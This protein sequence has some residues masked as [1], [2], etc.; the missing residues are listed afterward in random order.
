MD[1]YTNCRVSPGAFVHDMCLDFGRFESIEMS[2]F[3]EVALSQK[4]NTNTSGIG[5][6]TFCCLVFAVSQK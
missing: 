3:E 2:H 5:R 6:H 1:L 4:L